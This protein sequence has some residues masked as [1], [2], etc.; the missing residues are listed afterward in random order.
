EPDG[1]LPEGVLD[2]IALPE[3]AARLERLAADRPDVHWDRI[4]FSAK[5]S[6]YKAWFPLTGLWLDFDEADIAL[7][8]D[9]R[10]AVVDA[11]PTAGAQGGFRARLLVP[12][13]VVGGRRVEFFDGRWAVRHGLVATAVTVPHG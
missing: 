5:E 8:A 10:H 12:G 7:T 6:V 11:G 3:E 13:P 1:P 4:L 9:A 2:A